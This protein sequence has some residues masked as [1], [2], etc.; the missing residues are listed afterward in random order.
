MHPDSLWQTN[1]MRGT[2]KE[3]RNGMERKQCVII[4][5]KQITRKYKC[6]LCIDWRD[7][8]FHSPESQ[9]MWLQ[10]DVLL[11]L[12]PI[13]YA[14][15]TAISVHPILDT[16]ECI[17]CVFNR[18]ERFAVCISFF[19]P[20][21]A[22]YCRVCW[23][24][25][26]GATVIVNRHTVTARSAVDGTEGYFG[27]VCSSAHRVH[28]MPFNKWGVKE[29]HQMNLVDKHFS[30]AAVAMRLPLPLHLNL[31]LFIV[32]HF[33][34]YIWQLQRTFYVNPMQCVSRIFGSAF[35]SISF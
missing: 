29:T 22:S 34:W 13:H 1:E 33:Y 11:L 4:I 23:V 7:A 24:R 6:F 5:G 9:L 25:I 18:D 20:P 12:S 14:N 16:H 28:S 30:V 8:N 10:F 27:K 19:S 17:Y 3:Q 32:I 31:R 35:Y 21:P 15:R 2:E 26:A